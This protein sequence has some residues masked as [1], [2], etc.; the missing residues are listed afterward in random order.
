MHV[1]TLIVG[2]GLSGTLLS[3]FLHTSGQKVAVIDGGGKTT[4]RVAAGIINP[5]TGRRYHTTWMAEA[6][7]PFANATYQAIGKSLGVTLITAKSVIDFF[8][9]TDMREAFLERITTDNP[10]LHA[11]PDQN[12]FNQYFN[13]DFGSGEI[14][15]AYVVNVPA[16]LDAWRQLLE[17]KSLFV[18]A[19]FNSDALELQEKG[20][21]YDGITA[22][23]IIYCEGPWGTK[24]PFFER[25][26]YAPNKGEA[27]VIECPELMNTHIYK[28]GMLLAPMAEKGYFWAGASYAWDYKD[29]GPTEAFRER[30][31]A[32]LDS[33]LKKPYKVAAHRAGIRPATV[34]RRPFVG[35]HPEFK[36]VGLL[37]GMG[38]KGTSLAPFFANQ[39]AQHI[40][41]G[42]PITPEA[43]L[44]RFT[45][46]LTK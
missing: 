3:W 27:L 38:S 23:R 46:T 7:L 22:D 19:S 10:Y 30:T 25:L 11:Y 44:A 21:R 28:K 4:S 6:L 42:F 26:P 39:L 15:P 41:H 40:I 12:H 43:D 24:N 45:R 29:D 36:N 1:D 18:A 32:Q 14:R 34:E 2:Q 17:Q 20:I 16:M 8:P 37:N 31:T 13:Y 35:F 33:W 9:N 5:V